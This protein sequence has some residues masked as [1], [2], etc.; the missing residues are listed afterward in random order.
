MTSLSPEEK[1]M[2]Q[3]LPHNNYLFH[4]AE[5]PICECGGGC[6]GICTS[7]RETWNVMCFDGDNNVYDTTCDMTNPIGTIHHTLSTPALLETT[8]TR[9]DQ[10]KII[11]DKATTISNETKME[12]ERARIFLEAAQ[13]TYDDLV[14]VMKS[15]KTNET[16][17][18]KFLTKLQCDI[19]E[20]KVA[21][22]K[23]IADKKMRLK[24]ALEA[25]E[26]I[27]ADEL[28]LG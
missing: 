20:M 7:W 11:T 5:T 27:E 14:I 6:V 9:L 28:T 15:Y 3:S 8:Q 22:R 25:I 23:E 1:Q 4:V 19:D 24:V 12:V 21:R 17:E 10:Q 18:T 2:F 16:K 26:A 13:Q